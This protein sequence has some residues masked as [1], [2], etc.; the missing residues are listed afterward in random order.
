MVK[1]FIF[2]EFT[3]KEVSHIYNFHKM[4]C[5]LYVQFELNVHCSF[6]NFSYNIIHNKKNTQPSLQSITKAEQLKCGFP[7][8]KCPNYKT[9]AQINGLF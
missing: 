2:V 5:Y 6:L 7:H 9:H 8:L 4:D 1:K 3:V